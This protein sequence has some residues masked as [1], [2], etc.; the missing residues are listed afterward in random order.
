M[1]ALL[2]ALLLALLGWLSGDDE[3]GN[4]GI[5]CGRNNP[6][7]LELGLVG[8]RPPG[9]D[10]LRIGAA[11]TGESLELICCGS[12]DVDEVTLWRGF[13]AACGCSGG[14]FAG[15]RLSVGGGKNAEQRASCQSQ[16]C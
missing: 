12:V 9:D 5:C 8:V 14:G 4:L 15:G 11:N 13:A 1:R 3:A 2:R 7:A 16:E 10:L 6:F